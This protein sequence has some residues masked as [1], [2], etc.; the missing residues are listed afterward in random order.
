[1]PD[2]WVKINLC[3]TCIFQ[4][5]WVFFQGVL[6]QKTYYWT[7][8]LMNYWPCSKCSETNGN[9][10][11]VNG[12]WLFFKTAFVLK[13]TQEMERNCL[14]ITN[15]YSSSW[16]II[17]GNPEIKLIF[18]SGMFFVLKRYNE[19]FQI[20]SVFHSTYS[21]HFCFVFTSYL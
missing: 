20:K 1:M 11:K 19:Q 8:I 5:N 7:I 4:P 17:L 21:Y 18:H 3:K 14:S 9:F 10:M 16:Y 6:Q 13:D 12:K 15:K 2:L